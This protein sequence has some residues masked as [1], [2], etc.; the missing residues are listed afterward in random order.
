MASYCKPAA[1]KRRGQEKSVI[2]IHLA[3][4]SQGGEMRALV[5]L[6]PKRSEEVYHEPHWNLPDGA[7]H[8]SST[9]WFRLVQTYKCILSGKVSSHFLYE[10]SAAM[11]PTIRNQTMC[12]Q[13]FYQ[14][15]SKV[16]N[17]RW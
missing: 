14:E 8:L 1:L 2:L 7:V 4:S 11:E 16:F 6:S 15:W 12:A 9:D 3:G 10:A 13:V 17:S 5:Q